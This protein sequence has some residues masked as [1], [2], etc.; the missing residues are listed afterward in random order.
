MANITY[1][2]EGRDDHYGQWGAQGWGDKFLNLQTK[3]YP[4][5]GGW[6]KTRHLMPFMQ[7]AQNK[8]EFVMLVSGQKDHNSIKDYLNSTILL[9]NAFNEV[10]IG[11][12]KVTI[13]AI[14]E[15]VGLDAT[16]TFFAKFEDVVVAFKILY[17]DAT[18]NESAYI[19]NDGFQYSASRENFSLTNNKL[20]RM[21]LKHSN[22]G[23][24]TIAMW[25]KTAEGITTDAAFANFRATVLNTSTNVSNNEG[26]L[27]V[28][29]IT[30]QG[31]L[32]VKADL[33]LKKRIIY[34]NPS[35]LPAQ[36]LFNVD[37]VELG[38]KIMQKYQ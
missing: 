38:K 13:P 33:N 12:K 19:I 8:N 29:V 34:Y 22:N 23:K 27:D 5:N 37:G 35:P 32:G 11:N 17:D 36:F 21:T 25:W 31:K 7:V 2:M 28:S 3:N 15:Q 10:W 14:G 20:I 24:A 18:T 30:P 1:V 9:P 26:I 4:L 16:K 6:G